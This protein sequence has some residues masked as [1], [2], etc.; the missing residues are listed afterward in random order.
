MKEEKT[1]RTLC[2]G[3][4]H[5]GLLALREALYKSGYDSKVD[6]L[7]FMGDY[8][9]GWSESAQVVDFIIGLKEKIRFEM[10]HPDSIIC[11]LGN[12]DEW[13]RDFLKFGTIQPNWL[14]NGGKSTLASYNVLWEENGKKQ[15]SLDS[16]RKFFD[17]LHEYY[18]D[19]EGRAYVHAG[20]DP[21]AGCQG[22]I[23]YLRVWDRTMWNSVLSGKTITAHKELFIGHTTT[24]TQTCK[25]HLPEA[26]EEGQEIGQPINVPLNRKNDWN[27]DTGGGWGGKLTIMDVDT[28]EYWQSEFVKDLYPHEEGR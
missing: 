1:G 16:H 28:K 3:D 24:M 15:E 9:D 26:K 14:Y 7:I 21:E 5:G 6:N 17:T 10:R 22:T 20:C 2:V 27:I 19:K 18:I 23:P 11:L 25:S 4:V 13:A 12:H 8:V